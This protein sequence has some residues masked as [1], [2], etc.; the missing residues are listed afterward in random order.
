MIT[1]NI[2]NTMIWRLIEISLILNG[3]FLNK[4]NQIF[5]KKHLLSN[6]WNIW[7][8]M[9]IEPKIVFDRNRIIDLLSLKKS[10]QSEK[11]W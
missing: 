5:K 10:C 7:V 9:Y 2:Y 1:K 4:F 6:L 8:S 3:V 11:R